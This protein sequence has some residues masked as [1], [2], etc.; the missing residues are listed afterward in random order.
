MAKKSY[1]RLATAVLINGA[2]V[3][4]NISINALRVAVGCIFFFAL[5]ALTSIWLYSYLYILDVVLVLP[6][7]YLARSVDGER[8]ARF[9][10]EQWIAPRRLV[11][12]ECISEQGSSTSAAGVRAGTWICEK[13]KYDRICRQHRNAYGRSAPS[14]LVPY[15]LVLATYPQAGQRVIAFTDGTSV[16]WHPSKRVIEAN[17]ESGLQE[18]ADSDAIEDVI[19][20]FEEVINILDD[21]DEAASLSEI[22]ERERH[23]DTDIVSEAL[24]VAFRWDMIAV[25]ERSS[26][27]RL[28]SDDNPDYAVRLTRIGEDWCFASNEHQATTGKARR[29]AGMDQEKS[30]SINI[31]NFAGILNV[32]RRIAGQHVAAVQQTN[33]SDT[34]ILSYLREILSSPQITWTDSELTAIRPVVEEALAQGNPRL[35]GLK[36]AVNKLCSICG[37]VLIG[38]LGNG[39]YQMLLTYFH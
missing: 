8:L 28:Y 12:M 13:E 32:G 6:A 4:P 30:P 29:N 2:Y 16:T 39:A 26:S 19:G 1:D 9:V 33:I 15:Q 36:R 7:W 38:V 11:A 21:R 34:E 31:G 18:L 37:D 20:T 27:A 14:P 25:A 23:R 35:Q 24:L 17:E 5:T 22:L 3:T 10:H